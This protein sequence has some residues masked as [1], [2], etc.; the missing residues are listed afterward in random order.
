MTP[1]NVL[2]S[3]PFSLF[4]LLKFPSFSLSFLFFFFLFLSFLFFSFSFSSFFLFFISKEGLTALHTAVQSGNE[5]I[6]DKI[7]EYE[8]CDVDAQ[9]NVI[10][11]SNNVNID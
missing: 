3:P 9:T 11:Y 7:L 10:F 2:F 8:E 6:T 4:S 5:E 1:N